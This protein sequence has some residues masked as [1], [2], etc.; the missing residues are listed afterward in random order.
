MAEELEARVRALT[1][2]AIAVA[3]GQLDAVVPISGEGDDLDALAYALST[4]ADD[5]QFERR[6]RDAAERHSGDVADAFDRSPA[7]HVIVDHVRDDRDG[8][9]RF[10]IRR[11]NGT[12]ASVVGAE[13]AGLFEQDFLSF[14]VPTY[15][16][17][18]ARALAAV[19]GEQARSFE[20]ALRTSR[21]QVDIVGEA[22][23]VAGSDGIAIAAVDVSQRRAL[24]Q[25][26]AQAHRMDAV[27]RLAGGVAHDLNNVLLVIECS[28]GFLESDREGKAP[29]ED[30]AAI[31]AA[32]QRAAALTQQLLAF[33]Q[34]GA[35][36]PQLIDVNRSSR[37]GATLLQRTLGEDVRLRLTL[38]A[39]A[40]ATMIDPVQLER[41]LLNLAANARDAMPSGGELFIETRRVVVDERDARDRLHTE[42]GPHVCISVRDTGTGIAPSAIGSVFEPFFTTKEAGKGTGLGL[43]TCYG[44]VRQ[45][46]GRIVVSSDVG[47]GT[48][49]EV[50]LVAS[51]ERSPRST[52]PRA[53]SA[54]PALGSATLCLVDDDPAV[55]TVTARVLSRG[56]YRVEAYESAAE[57]LAA[58][59]EG[60]RFDLLVTD[61]VMPVTSGKQLVDQLRQRGY[62]GVVLFL[63]GYTGNAVLHRGVV[64]ESAAFMSKPFSPAELLA[65]VELL[66]GSARR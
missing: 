51:D 52:R 37:E 28:L 57:V 48:T 11:C 24:E 34:G 3:S 66:L 33:A 53:A 46:D 56:G 16:R 6:R 60:E 23:A 8:A 25:Q 41:V 5:L 44:I 35:T 61:V 19:G 29:N 14:V 17:A 40:G 64:E 58:Y 62:G 18:L 12:F 36:R 32:T 13:P 49:F 39:E 10:V 7:L 38:G 2:A 54:M 1:E 20:V 22:R 4:L 50:Y 59:D 26:L 47:R 31:R 9:S 55:R 15:H 65:R 27:G 43:S 21:G 30:V 63:S 45:V 42:P